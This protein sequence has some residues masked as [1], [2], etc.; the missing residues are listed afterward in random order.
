[1]YETKMTLT[2]TMSKEGS[3]VK[4]VNPEPLLTSETKQYE[5]MR[6]TFISKMLVAEFNV[7]TVLCRPFW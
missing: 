3:I 6:G 5:K 4:R 1:M 7:S 2:I